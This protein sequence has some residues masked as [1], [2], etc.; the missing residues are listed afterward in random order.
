MSSV[1][2]SILFFVGHPISYLVY[3]IVHR[4]IQVGRNIMRS[5]VTS[6]T[7]SMVN[8][9]IRPECSGLYSTEL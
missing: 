9:E 3:T 4:I 1:H 6:P 7:E 5:V 2:Y 8:Y